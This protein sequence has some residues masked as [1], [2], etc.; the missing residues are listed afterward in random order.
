T[1]L[2][3]SP[4]ARKIV[5]FNLLALVVLVAGVLFLN[6]FRGSLVIQHQRALVAQV[7][8]L[9]DVFEARLP[10][11][12][13]AGDGPE[14]QAVLAALDLDPGVEAWL[15]DRSG[16][17]IATTEGAARHVAPPIDGLG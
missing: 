17:L 10:S 15:F 3:Q 5:T 8:L 12:L 2:N 9:A 4:L 11:G 6:P 1:I 13:A 16:T 7:Q 14:A